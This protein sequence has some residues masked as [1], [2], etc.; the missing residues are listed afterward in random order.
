MAWPCGL[1]LWPAVGE[2]LRVL[3]IKPGYPPHAFALQP[4]VPAEAVARIRHAMLEMNRT[5]NGR[6]LLKSIRIDGLGAA[7]DRGWDDVRALNIKLLE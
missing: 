3:W 6:A 7:A 1:C 4:R 2:Q 5:P